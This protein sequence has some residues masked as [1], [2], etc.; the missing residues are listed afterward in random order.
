MATERYLIGYDPASGDDSSTYVIARKRDDG[1][2]EILADWSV[3]TPL[4][5]YV[6][7]YQRAYIDLVMKRLREPW[8]RKVRWASLLVYLFAAGFAFVLSRAT[9]SPWEEA[10]AWYVLVELT[11]FVFVRSLR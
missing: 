11:A 3:G 7:P 6:R 8:W 2:I 10:V 9:Q 4:S 5:S 1:T